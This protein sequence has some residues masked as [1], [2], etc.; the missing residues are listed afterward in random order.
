MFAILQRDDRR[1]AKAW[2]PA[3]A[4]VNDLTLSQPSPM[5]I[6]FRTCHR[7]PAAP[8]KSA[9]EEIKLAK[10]RGLAQRFQADDRSRN[11]T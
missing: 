5:P 11:E 1:G 9:D 3:K 8:P 10:P 6:E 7:V 4:M 2:R